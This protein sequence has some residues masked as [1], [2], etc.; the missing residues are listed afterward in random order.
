MGNRKR[1]RSNI[2]ELLKKIEE[3]DK[4]MTLDRL[5]SWEPQ[6]EQNR[7]TEEGVITICTGDAGWALLNDFKKSHKKGNFNKGKKR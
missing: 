1:I 3:K 7:L 4:N 2:S 6:K 5:F